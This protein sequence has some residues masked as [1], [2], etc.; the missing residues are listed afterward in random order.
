MYIDYEKTPVVKVIAA[1]IRDTPKDIDVNKGSGP[2]HIPGI[3]YRTAPGLILIFFLS[4]AL[5]HICISNKMSD[6]SL[7]PIV[8]DSHKDWSSDDDHTPIAM[9]TVVPKVFEKLFLRD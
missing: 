4:L 2:D 1:K 8:K 7:V 9:E 5:C 3:F 6:T